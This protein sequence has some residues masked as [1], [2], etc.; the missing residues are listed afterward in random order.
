MVGSRLHDLGRQRQ[1]FC[2]THLA[3]VASLADNHFRIIKVTDGKT[4]RTGI[5]HLTDDERVEELARM[6]GGV[7][8]TQATRDHATEML[9]GGRRRRAI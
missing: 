1:I 9:N 3:Q 2:V 7:T 4:T 6:L 8:I 5:S